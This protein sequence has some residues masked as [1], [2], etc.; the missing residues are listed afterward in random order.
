[1]LGNK[2]MKYFVYLLKGVLVFFIVEILSINIGYLFGSGTSEIGLIVS[3]ISILSAIL[4]VCT[5]IIVDTI[6]NNIS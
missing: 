2:N 1:M 3:A 5:L 6:K 4:V